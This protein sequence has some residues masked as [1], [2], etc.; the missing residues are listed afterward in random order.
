M[1]HMNLVDYYAGINGLVEHKYTKTEIDQMIPF[2]RD[3]IVNLL[4]QDAP[5]QVEPREAPTEH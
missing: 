3:I 5:A 2:E 4:N 1:S